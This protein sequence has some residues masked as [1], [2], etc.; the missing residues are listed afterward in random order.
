MQAVDSRGGRGGRGAWLGCLLLLCAAERGWAG[1]GRWTGLGGLPGGKVKVVAADPADPQL[2]FA[3]S[4]RAGLF[5][6]LDGGVSW[7]AVTGLPRQAAAQ[8]VVFDPRGTRTAIVGL[9]GQAFKSE[10]GGESWTPLTGGPFD[11]S[12]LSL[13]FA[14][15]HPEVVY[16]VSSNG[17]FRSADRGATWEQRTVPFVAAGA[18]AVSPF[19]PD[20]LFVDL[21]RSSDGGRSWTLAHPD[22][23]APAVA[24]VLFA[25]MAPGVVLAL[26]S[27]FGVFRSDDG[28]QTWRDVTPTHA[29][30]LLDIA[31]SADGTTLFAAAEALGNGE[32]GTFFQ[33]SRDGGLHWTQPSALSPFVVDGLVADPA[34]R[35]RLFATSVDGIYWSA[36]GGRKWQSRS[37]GLVAAGVSDLVADPRVPGTVYAVNDDGALSRSRD[38]GA[39]WQFLRGGIQAPLAVDPT[40]PGTVYAESTRALAPVRGTHDGESWTVLPL[41]LYCLIYAGMAVDPQ[42][43]STLYLL[44]RTG[45]GSGCSG[46]GLFKSIDAGSTWNRLPAA[47]VL[48][49]LAIGA[50]GQTLYG[51]ALG[52]VARSGD[53]GQTWSLSAPFPPP[54]LGNE[55]VTLSRDTAWLYLSGRDGSIF[56]SEDAA[57]T[58]QPVAPSPLGSTLPLFLVADPRVSTTVYGFAAGHFFRSLN[59]G[60]NWI[61]HSAGLRPF[62]LTGPLV[63]DPDRPGR[64]LAGTASGEVIEIELPPSP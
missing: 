32:L 20:T 22:P 48:T 13:A 10:D 40:N 2:V 64:V 31:F 5:R 59:G 15:N 42:S 51:E 58:W 33:H 41:S 6:S 26:V 38:G 37:G 34:A 21:L 27:G 12:L 52:D 57:S 28:G 11:G 50:P 46:G 24:R 36:D 47:P 29:G 45:S 3:G 56:R 14:P 25:P 17:V 39:T 62:K 1:V 54:A 44:A 35:R 53:G 8:V 43:P 19:D 9:G 60:A 16:G 30:F 7:Q 4:E 61:G 55:N 18:L 23:R 49:G 63:L